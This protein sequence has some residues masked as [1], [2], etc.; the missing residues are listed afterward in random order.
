VNEVDISTAEIE[1]P[2]WLGACRRFAEAVLEARSIRNWEVSI[3]LC[4]DSFI[5]N[6]NERYRGVKAPTD[7]LSFSQLKG[8]SGR[9]AP[10]GRG[11]TAAGDIVISLDTMRRNAR[12]N[13]QAEEMELKRL[14]IH[15]ILHLQGINHPEEGDSEMIALQEL[16]L[17]S[18][19]E[20]RIF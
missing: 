15:G 2:F 6:L 9:S 12:E 10:G 19:A 7:V 11:A 3:L 5:T 16:I 4:N 13:A 14:L 8:D 18:L 1:A 20:V 17:S